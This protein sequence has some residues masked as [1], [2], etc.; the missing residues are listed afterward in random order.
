MGL[1]VLGKI[2][3]GKLTDLVFCWHNIYFKHGTPDHARSAFGI[4]YLTPSRGRPCVR[5][6]LLRR[7]PLRRPDA[8]YIIL[9]R[10]ALYLP[11]DL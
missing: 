3:V 7:S 8:D 5:W 1:N 2:S 6:F 10:R 4:G 9:H 11:I